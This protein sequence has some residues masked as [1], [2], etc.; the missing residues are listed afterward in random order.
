[1]TSEL[2]HVKVSTL[3]SLV[4]IVVCIGGSILISMIRDKKSQ[5]L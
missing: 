1:M 2:I 5:S 4:F 3:V